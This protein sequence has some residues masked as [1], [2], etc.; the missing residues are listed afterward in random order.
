M[1]FRLP[2]EF[3][4]PHIRRLSGRIRCFVVLTLVV[5]LSQ[6]WVQ[7]TDASLAFFH[8][9]VEPILR[10]HCFPCHS[11]D[12]GTMEGGLALDWKSGWQQGGTRGPAIIPGSTENSLL[13]RAVQHADPELKMPETKL[14]D[15]DI[16]K[17][18]QWVRSG[19]SDDRT[20]QPETASHAD[21]RDW[22]SLRPLTRPTIPSVETDHPIDAFIID[23]LQ[24]RGL[25]LSAEADRATLL[26]RVTYDLTGLP[27][28]ASDYQAFLSDSSHDAYQR[29]VDR[30]LQSPRYGERWARHWMDTI[31]F[32]ESHGFEHD[33]ARDDAWRFRDY[34][35]EA[36][37]EDIT[38]TQ[39]IREQLAADQFC[40]QEPRRWRALGFLG[41]GPFDLSAYSTAPVSF[42]YIDRDDMVTQ[43]MAAFTSSTV[44]CA[45]CHAHKFDPISQE[46]YYA[47]QAVFAGVIKGNMAIDEDPEVA[48]QRRTWTRVQQAAL[49]ADRDILLSAEYHTLIDEWLEKRGDSA[50]W[51]IIQ[52]Q[53]FL[54]SDGATL[55][56]A[57]TG[58][59]YSQG[60][61]PATDTY[62]FT[63][64]V[65]IQQLT[66]MRLEVLTDE[67]LPK[68]GPG[69]QDNG[70]LHLSEVEVQLFESGAEKPKRI[71]I[72]QAAADFNQ[73]GWGIERAIDGKTDTAWGIF[74][75]V[76]QDHTAVFVFAT[77]VTVPPNS[78]LVIRLKQLHGGGHL[79]GKLR[80]AVTADE[81]RTA[82]PLPAEVEAALVIH[83]DS[84]SEAQRLAIATW[85][86]RKHAE[87]VLSQLPPP[88]RI[89]AA[90]ASVEIP[91]G[92]GKTQSRSLM[93]PRPVHVLRRG[94]F[95]Q[96]QAE[97]TP[98]AMSAL[99]EL[100]ARF[101][102]EL[103][104]SEPQR[105]AAL[106]DWISDSRNVLTWR[107]AVNRMW[108]FHFGRGL[109]DTPSDLGRMGSEP[110]HRELIDWLAVWFRDEAQ[111]SL[112]H[113]HRLICTSAAYRQQSTSHAAGREIDADNRWLWR[114]NR[115]RLDADA[116]RDFTLTAS[117]ALDLT[118]GGPSVQ[119]FVQSK[120][121]QITP[122]LDYDAYRWGQAHS[123]RRSIY[124]FVWRGI[125]DPLMEALD[126]PDLGLLAPARS[127]SVS[128]LQSLAVYNHDFILHHSKLLGERV[129]SHGVNDTEGVNTMVERVWGRS[130]TSAE[131][132]LMVAYTQQYGYA[133][134]AR[135][136][137]NS[138]EFHFVD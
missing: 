6:T 119:H 62:S 10:K 81:P 117:E 122:K 27:P 137:L 136:L 45:R 66:A 103:M 75:A 127:S 18:L 86:L 101:S 50:H 30:L 34:L 76:G 68:G 55:Q 56:Q 7:A 8:Q 112:K 118:V 3:P 38:W 61:R 130:P 57:P 20:L 74:P 52:P 9:E 24:K 42:E 116:V 5:T 13:I 98:G 43:T 109:C 77:P 19:A 79:I 92:D 104:A 132:Q 12:S 54:S 82:I 111:G 70:N 108:R 63:W 23:A 72:R 49:A 15:S 114:Q 39:F 37:N 71:E 97:A 26:R 11:H 53:T 105:R 73:T 100:P 41:A 106:A 22:W 28:S 16:A 14:S 94:D 51:T 84:R 58:V 121:P 35:I 128:P 65:P 102:L 135:V 33:L 89:Y 4:V 126:F 138:N 90:A 25:S 2:A 67:R 95:S 85:V 131:V 36:L 129:E 120:G 125:P 46:D 59:I 83:S 99:S 32:A 124:R 133:A 96:P 123:A 80:L 21:R 64:S 93:Q 1:T 91:A 47:L 134:L 87:N 107:S 40:I 110:T 48:T 29:V 113:L 17:L 31:H 69:R 88:V 60:T 78:Q 44:N 115:Q